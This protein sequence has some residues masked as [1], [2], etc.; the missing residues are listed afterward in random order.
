MLTAPWEPVLSGNLSVRAQ[1]TA[2]AIAQKCTSSE[3]L[4][5][6]A[7]KVRWRPHTI[8]GGNTGLS[9][10]Y[11][12]AGLC[13]LEE[14]WNREAYASLVIALD[15]YN[16]QNC[17]PGLFIGLSGLGFATTYASRGGSHYASLRKTLDTLL[18]AQISAFLQRS[19]TR[20][21]R[22][23]YYDVILGAAGMLAYL[24]FRNSLSNDVNL[25]AQAEALIRF[26]LDASGTSQ[27]T[28]YLILPPDMPV[29]ERRERYP[30]G[31]SDYGIA[32]GIPGILA[33]L[34]LAVRT[35]WGG[36]RARSELAR[37]TYWFVDQ[38]LKL[39]DVITWPAM[40]PPHTSQGLEGMRFTWCYGVAGIS[41]ALYL[42][43]MILDDSDLCRF[44][45]HTLTQFN[46]IPFKQWHTTEP[47]LCHGLAG[48][49]QASL[50][51]FHDTHDEQCKK[52]AQTVSKEL[53]ARYNPNSLFGFT[54]N[55]HTEKNTDNPGL[56]SGAAGIALALL[57]AST[58][59]APAW[60]RLM[61]IS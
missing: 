57:S 41:R 9:V 24:S 46:T 38:Q 19:Q 5:E 32:H 14:V 30:E 18:A 60:D 37:L 28:P 8:A 59:I 43:G 11:T 53:L 44:A 42:T 20:P 35:G 33:A 27:D 21:L 12:Y 51:M 23:E 2:I 34:A 50:R 49:L 56:L 26:L 40:A 13:T 10:L 47:G 16:F 58:S 61:L 29:A 31:Y 4:T 22:V 39:G 55:T 54:E 45:V 1:K 15:G 7:K 36:P 6:A 25:T 17:Q 3:R 48:V 52:L